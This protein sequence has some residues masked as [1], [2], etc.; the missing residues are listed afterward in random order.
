MVSHRELK[1]TLPTPPSGKHWAIYMSGPRLV[2]NR[3]QEG[4]VKKVIDPKKRVQNLI[5]K[6]MT[7]PKVPLTPEEMK[8]KREQKKKAQKVWEELMFA[9]FGPK[10]KE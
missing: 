10:L 7:K 6:M 8:V 5:K 9:K 3:T 1:A 2:S 4:E